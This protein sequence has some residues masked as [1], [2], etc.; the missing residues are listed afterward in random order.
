MIWDCNSFTQI[1]NLNNSML[2][3]ALKYEMFGNTKKAA[4]KLKQFLRNFELLQCW[5]G[6]IHSKLIDS[7]Q[8]AKM[9][10][11]IRNDIAKMNKTLNGFKKLSHDIIMKL[12]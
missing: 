1:C 7:K 4:S 10:K 5:L 11:K 9:V 3:V 8:D 2:N 12:E 6:E